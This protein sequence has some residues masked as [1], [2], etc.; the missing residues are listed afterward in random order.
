VSVVEW[1]GVSTRIWVATGRGGGRYAQVRERKSRHGRV[2]AFG[3]S[4]GDDTAH[5][6]MRRGLYPALNAELLLDIGDAVK[7]IFK[8][9]PMYHLIT[10]RM[11]ICLNSSHSCI[12]MI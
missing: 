12:E 6:S 8:L 7:Y 4:E 9:A 1:G 2:A 11:D 10:Q 5:A 3:G